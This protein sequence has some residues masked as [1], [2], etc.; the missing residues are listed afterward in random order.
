MRSVIMEFLRQAEKF[1]VARRCLM[2]PHANGIADSM[3]DAFEA[4]AL[5]LR[6]L[7]RGALDARASAW[8]AR[9]EALMNTD[10]IDGADQRER[11]L[12]RAAEL[13]IEEQSDLSRLVDE[14]AHWFARPAKAAQ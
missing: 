3:A 4:C 13:T 2:L 8:V 7:H 9:V 14:L 1:S 12:K 6:S 5:G 10:A 11:W